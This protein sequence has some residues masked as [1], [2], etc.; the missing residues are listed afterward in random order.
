MLVS[1]GVSDDVLFRVEHVTR[2][3][4]LPRT[5]LFGPRRTIAAVSDVSLDVRRE[6]TLGVVGESGSGKTTLMKLMLGLER[7][8]HGRVTYDGTLERLRGD[9]D[10]ETAV[11]ALYTGELT[12]EAVEA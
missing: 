12:T 6:E 1:R 10:L 3:Y 9:L 2:T 11:K 5:S 4:N 7:P 8:D